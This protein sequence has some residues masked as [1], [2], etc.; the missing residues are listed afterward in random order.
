MRH[1][2]LSKTQN[3][4]QSPGVGI[5]PPQ[6]QITHSSAHPIEQLQGSIGN[7]AVNRLLANHPTIQ[8]KP[9]FR[10][11]SHELAIQPKLTIGAI[12]DKYEQ[13]ADRMASQVVEQIHAPATAQSTPGH[14]VQRQEKP[15]EELQ[16][17]PS[18]AVIPS[19]TARSHTGRRRTPSKVNP[20][21][22]G[23]D[24]RRGSFNGFGIC[25]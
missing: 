3:A 1:Q 20:T 12:G 16:A 10:G 14:S 2:H 21:A 22:S 9:L 23:S 11:L 7:R 25:H 15:E 18:I 8:A 17:K 6:S 19:D 24:R 13:E 5:A 4:M